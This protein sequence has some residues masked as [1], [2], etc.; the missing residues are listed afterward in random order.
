MPDGLEDVYADAVMQYA[1]VHPIFELDVNSEF[2]PE[3]AR[4]LA[5]YLLFYLISLCTS[6]FPKNPVPPVKNTTLSL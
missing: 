6:S 1:L 4:K 3:F 5:V 2:I